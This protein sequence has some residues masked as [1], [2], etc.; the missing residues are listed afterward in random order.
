MAKALVFGT[1]DCAFESHQGR[2]FGIF[3]TRVLLAHAP[4]M[5]LGTIQQGRAV[6]R[7][8]D[9]EHGYWRVHVQRK[10]LASEDPSRP[11][12]EIRKSN[13]GLWVCFRWHVLIILDFSAPNLL[14]ALVITYRSIQRRYLRKSVRTHSIVP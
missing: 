12:I 6:Q 3:E 7:S 9:C 5:V 10:S 13:P 14:A 4:G 1:K 2:S 8:G 11:S